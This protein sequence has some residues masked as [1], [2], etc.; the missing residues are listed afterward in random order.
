[1]GRG[2]E[3][4]TG[5][6]LWLVDHAD[7]GFQV[8]LRSGHKPGE[9][10]TEL[11]IC[12]PGRARAEQRGAASSVRNIASVSASMFWGF[13]TSS[14][15]RADRDMSHRADRIVSQGGS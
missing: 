5:S 4:D 9:V 13:R 11:K 14:P 3:P 2:S 8:L 7:H 15:V 6:T 10:I 12:A 1:M